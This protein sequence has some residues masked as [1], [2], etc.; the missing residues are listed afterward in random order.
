MKNPRFTGQR[1]FHRVRRLEFCFL[2]VVLTF[3]L[4]FLWAS[5]NIHRIDS[6]PN[7]ISPQNPYRRTRRER[8]VTV[9]S[10]EV[11]DSSRKPVADRVQRRKTTKWVTRAKK[12]GDTVGKKS[13]LK[14]DTD[15]VV[16]PVKPAAENLRFNPEK[17]GRKRDG[18]VP[19]KV[20]LPVFVA[21]LPK[22]GTT[23][24]FQYFNCGGHPASHQWVKYNDTSNEQTGKCI[25]RNVQNGLAPFQGCGGLSDIFTDTGFAICLSDR[26]FP[27][28]PTDYYC[29]SIQAL[30]AIYEHYPDATIVN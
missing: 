8:A 5:T 27:L 10:S 29:P 13:D 22:S 7:A 1:L 3:A 16:K 11:N 25:R 12:K 14:A 20:G 2:V 21:S 18:P 24:M 6:S 28:A 15:Q 30:D 23:S 9:A 19:L 4:Q 17:E 26:K